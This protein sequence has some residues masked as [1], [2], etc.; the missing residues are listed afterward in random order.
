[1]ESALSRASHQIPQS[2]TCPWCCRGSYM[3]QRSHG[4]LNSTGH[5]AGDLPLPSCA[6]MISF[7]NSTPIPPLS[8]PSPP[9]LPSGTG[10]TSFIK[11]LAQHT[12]RSI[13]S[14]P[15]TKIHTNQELMDIM[16]DSK[17]QVST[18]GG[19]HT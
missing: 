2:S 13:I 17:I 12:K 9:P 8:P 7:T 6:G 1:M 14:I 19:A 11:A 10:K 4:P 3:V 18:H 5:T 15:L 16:F